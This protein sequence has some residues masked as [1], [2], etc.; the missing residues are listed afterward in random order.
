M[1]PISSSFFPTKD[2][3]VVVGT[4]ITF[5]TATLAA[6][7]WNKYQITDFTIPEL[8]APAET[9]PQRSDT[10]TQ[11]DNSVHRRLDNK[12]YTFDLTLKGTAAALLFA[13]KVLVEDGASPIALAGDYSF[14]A[15]YKDGSACTTAVTV[16]F[17]NIGGNDT[18][19]HLLAKSCVATNAEFTIGSGSNAGELMVKLTMLTAYKPDYSALVATSPVED[20]ASAKSI[21]DSLSFTMDSDPM[22]LTDFS[23]SIA[24]TV[25]RVGYKDDTDYDPFGL[26]MTGMFEVTGSCTIKKDPNQDGMASN[27]I[28]NSG[29]PV[30]LSVTGLA[31]SIPLF[32]VEEGGNEKGGNIMMA[33]VPF[34]AFGDASNISINVVSITAS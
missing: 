23:L 4:E 11:L 27:Y 32:I 22:F 6:G 1:P 15:A 3:S 13:G 12:V 30:D 8:A 31:I 9:T 16:L 33:T 14:P 28:G 17:Q 19:K 7:T 26:A 5:G 25:E 34:R 24:R 21:F 18:N 29:I 2:V 10:T 20:T